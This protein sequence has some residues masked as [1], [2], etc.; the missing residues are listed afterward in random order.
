MVRGYRYTNDQPLDPRNTGGGAS[1]PSRADWVRRSSDQAFATL[2]QVFGSKV[3]HEIKTGYSGFLFSTDG[4]VPFTPTILLR[5]YQIGKNAV[6]PHNVVED[7]YSVRD[8]LT[9][10]LIGRGRHELKLGAEA[11]YNRATISWYQARDGIIDATGGPIPSNIEDLFPVWNDISTWN[12]AGLSPITR[13]VRQSF[14]EHYLIDPKKIGAAWVQENWTLNRRLTLNLGLRY[15]V[16]IGALGEDYI[17]P[18]FLPT[19]RPSDTLNFQP[20]LGFAYSL[21]DNKTVIRGGWGKYFG[22]MTDNP[23]HATAISI[24]RVIPETLNDGRP[25]FTADPYNGRPPTYEEVVA[26]GVRRD[27]ASLIT[28]PNYHTTYSYQGSIGL[29][30]Q[31]GATMSVE[32]D[33]AY[34]GSRRDQSSR[35][36][37]LSYNPATGANYPFSDISRRPYPN[38]GYIST[39]YTDAWSDYHG[40]QTSF[41]KRFSNRWQ[42]SASYT[43]SGLWNSQGAPDVGFPLAPDVGSEYTLA[44]NDQRHRAV[45]NGIWQLPYGFQL[46]GLYFFGSGQRYAT[47]YGADL[48]DT[49]GTVGRLRPDGTIVPRN[50]FVG[51]PLHRVDLRALRQFP[52]L[53]HVRIDG[54]FEVF[55]VL[56][57][58]NYGSYVTTESSRIYGRPQQNTNVAYQ[59]RMLQLGFRLTF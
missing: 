11:M 26:S 53:G 14:G 44:E 52:I 24:L 19:K 28:N 32:A 23:N 9:F 5:G 48:R 40:L 54:I 45:F 29:A 22:E 27:T 57:Y 2:T 37:N 46:S 55:N 1:H 12:L 13:R 38:W 42:A 43:L 50:N 51:D 39:F 56:N 7:R 15:D 25:N 41:T 47:P 8:D 36:Q 16:S 20:R 33:Y 3:V 30:R 34:A 21:Q 17:F 18:P 31:V 59:P 35:N 10:L 58:A 6:D 49:G 4:I